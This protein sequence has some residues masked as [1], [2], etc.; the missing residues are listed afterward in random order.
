[1]RE[2]AGKQPG[3]DWLP[4][5]A[6]ARLIAAAPDLLEACKASLLYWEDTDAPIANIVRDAIAMA[7][8]GDE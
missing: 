8:G 1:M 7:E 3:H 4:A 5:E 2:L 6:N